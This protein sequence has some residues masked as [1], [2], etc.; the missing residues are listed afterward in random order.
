MGKQKIHELK[1]CCEQYPRYHTKDG[2]TWVQCPK[3]GKK[4]NNFLTAG[5][6]AN[7]EWNKINE[8]QNPL[9]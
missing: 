2:V 1:K 9:P 4:T 8:K 6:S 7:K 3:C 5:I